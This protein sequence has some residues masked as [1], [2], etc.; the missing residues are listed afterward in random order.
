M[1][2]DGQ[3]EPKWPFCKRGVGVGVPP[4]QQART[5]R[6]VKRMMGIG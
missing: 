2:N 5:E 3:P 6:L 4:Y 1:V